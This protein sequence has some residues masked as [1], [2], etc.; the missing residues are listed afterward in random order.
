MKNRHFNIAALAGWVLPLLGIL[1][2]ASCK[3]YN[4]LGYTPGTGAPSITSIHTY[5]KTDSTPVNDTVISYNSAG[6]PTF[7]INT[8]GPRPVPF[9]SVTTAGSLGNYYLIEGS[10]LGDATTITFNGYTAYFNRAL[11]TDHSIL[12]QVPSKTPYYGAAANDSLVVTTTHGVASYKF[13][14]LAPAPTV[15][16]YS[17]YDFTSKNNFQLT[18]KGVGFATVTGVTLQGTVSGSTNVTIASQ[19]DSVMVLSFPSSTVSRGML[20]FAYNSGG[21]TL[22]A[23]G[24]Q[25]LV[26]IDV[27]YQIFANS[28]IAPGW[29]SWSWDNAQITNKMSMTSASTWNAQ[30]SGGG[31]KID[32]FREGGGT[33]TDGLA[34]SSAYT[35]L[36]MWVY[37]G[38]AKETLYVE[39]GNEG[40]NNSG[41]NEINA[42]TV[43]PG[44]WNY[45]KVPIPTLLWNTSATNWAANSSTLLN[46]CAF[47]MNSNSVTE[48]LYFD[49][50]VI[51]K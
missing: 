45:F 13:T 43:L 11:S 36:V 25:E 4:Y 34:Y 29:G 49:D 19:N 33:A 50:V 22:T 1:A 26:N 42:L 17:D 15:S 31:W 41:A 18:L 2:I 6:Q 8:Q 44:V 51:V 37:G 46:T 40:F 39:W 21:T 10:N 24:S 38:T 32:G 48:Q 23:V 35:Y 5:Y 28:N 27:A 7:T 20:A 14:I 30:F 3:K 9:D 16:S 47:F 12:V